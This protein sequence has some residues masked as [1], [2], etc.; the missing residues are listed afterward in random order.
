L[1]YDVA[2][3]EGATRKYWFKARRYGYGWEPASREGWA[4][5]LG[6]LGA[7]L[8]AIAVATLVGSEAAVAVVAVAGGAIMAAV[9]IVISLK[10]GEK[11][12]WRWG[13]K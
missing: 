10:T 13:G 4:V 8:L 3:A 12:R 9:L 5:L 11:P 6:V 7:Y 1:L 2:M